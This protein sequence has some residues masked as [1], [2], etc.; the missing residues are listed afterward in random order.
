MAMPKNNTHKMAMPKY[1][2]HKMA[3]PKN[4]THK[5]AMTKNNT[6]K[7]A[8]PKNN[9]HKVA[10]PKNIS[11]KMAMPKKQHKQFRYRETKTQNL[12]TRR[13]II[14]SQGGEEYATYN[15]LNEGSITG[16][17]TSWLEIPSKKRY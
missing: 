1:N 9:T 5:M 13:S 6:H 10:M 4:N 2:T 15:K 8:M 12:E 17:V 7:M 11:H 14:S 16:L 3:T